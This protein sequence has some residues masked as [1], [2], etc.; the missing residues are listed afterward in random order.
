[1]VENDAR[2]TD[3]ETGQLEIVWGEGFLSPGGPPEIS[4][5]LGNHS[6][7]GCELLDIGSGSGGV[8]IVLAQKHGA[9]T[10]VGIDVDK[11]L[12]DLANHR[13]R[14]FDLES[15]IKYQL[16]EPGPLPFH[17]NAFDVV[18]SKDAIIHIQDKRD[19][20]SEV[21][22][23]VRPGGRLF[24]SD[25]LRGE[26]DE[27]DS[28]VERFAEV[29]GHDFTLVSLREIGK[30]LERLGFEEI[31]LT[32]RQAWY[33]SEATA[34]L[35]KMRGPLH[36]QLHDQIEFWEI[37]VDALNEGAIMPGHIRAKK[38]LDTQ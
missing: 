16:V 11:K 35:E 21:F 20:Y 19:L 26:G 25:W 34:E 33:S 18:F 30:I 38:P 31:E 12:V 24:V 22:R 37:M 10:V 8:D 14:R 5:I 36:A 28:T 3:D 7:K 2:Y 17:D 29:S 15:R 4:R 27:F 32:D 13:L 1:M 6:I 9:G 23:V